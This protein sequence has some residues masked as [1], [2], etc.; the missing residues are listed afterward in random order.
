MRGQAAGDDSA[1]HENPI[2]RSKRLV[3][4]DEEDAP[5][6]VLEDTNQSLTKA[7]YEALVA[8]KDD[9]TDDDPKSAGTETKEPGAKQQV[10]ANIAEVGK[11]AKKRKAKVIG[12]G[13]GDGEDT[14][15][16]DTKVIKKVKKP[17][18]KTKP[19]K[20]SFGDQE[21]G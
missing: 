4:D 10:K 17:K 16:T 3:Q 14:E 1:R 20:L 19:V 12:T 7:E 5:T 13:D 9:P 18:K 8:G 2:P 6:Y 15:D 21:E 11:A